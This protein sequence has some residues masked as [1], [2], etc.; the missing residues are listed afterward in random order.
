VPQQGLLDDEPVGEDL[1]GIRCLG[2]GNGTSDADDDPGFQ[3]CCP[4]FSVK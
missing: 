3:G 1:G 4:E 2:G